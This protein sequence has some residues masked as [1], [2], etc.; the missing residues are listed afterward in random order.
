MNTVNKSREAVEKSRTEGGGGCDD[1]AGLLF[2]KRHTCKL[3]LNQIKFGETTAIDNDT[4][5][6]RLKKGKVIPI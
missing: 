4:C 6:P 1:V 3:T 2:P 5:S